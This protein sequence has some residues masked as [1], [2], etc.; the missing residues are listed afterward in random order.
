VTVTVADISSGMTAFTNAAISPT[1]FT[2][3]PNAFGMI[4]VHTMKITLKDV[5]NTIK[6]Y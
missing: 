3:T 5:C 6:E 4:G 2:V 1:D